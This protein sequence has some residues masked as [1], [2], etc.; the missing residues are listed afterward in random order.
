MATFG[1][2]NVNSQLTLKSKESS[3]RRRLDR[4]DELEHG[5]RWRCSNRPPSLYSCRSEQL[6]HLHRCKVGQ[7]CRE[8]PDPV[9]PAAFPPA[10]PAPPG[11]PLPGPPPPS[12][13]PPPP[14]PGPPLTPPT[15]AARCFASLVAGP[16]QRPMCL[17]LHLRGRSKCQTLSCRLLFVI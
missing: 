10:P 12:P 3:K 5:R 2:F 8:A 14:L 7:R 16:P 11:R 6:K 15:K 4:D 9:A 1:V 13:P 17:C